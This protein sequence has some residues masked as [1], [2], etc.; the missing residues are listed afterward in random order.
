MVEVKIIQGDALEQLQKLPSESAYTC[1]TSPPYYGLRDYGTNGQIGTEETPEEYIERL[2]AVFREVRRVLRHDGTLWVN[3]GDSYAGSWRGRNADGT[4]ANTGDN[5]RNVGSRAG[6]VKKAKDSCKPKDLIGIPWMLAFALRADGWYL[7]QDIIWQKPNAMPESVKDRCTKSHEY[8]FLLSKSRRYFYDAEAISEPIADSSVK[9]YQEDISAQKGSL[10]VQKGKKGPMKA[11]PPRYGGKKYTENPD[12]FYRTKSGTMYEVR[13][14]RNRRDV[15]TI[16]TASFKGAHFAT[17]P[18]K[19]VEPCVLAG[20]PQG[21]T[22]IDPFMGSGTT[23]VVAKRLGR[24]F[25]GIEINP[26]YCKLAEERINTATE[27][28]PAKRKAPVRRLDGQ[29]TLEGI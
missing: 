18:E 19:L 8:I 20:S 6:T 24:D 17:F 10:R 16:S 5:K 13:P 26:E 9:R 22:V 3:I 29:M 21:G 2:T 11:V 25:V 28:K 4:A 27:I 14:R 23:G 12:A 1:I 15:W 7:R